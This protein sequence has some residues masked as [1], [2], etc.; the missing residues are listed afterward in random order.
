MQRAQES[1]DTGDKMLQ[2]HYYDW[3]YFLLR[4][5]GESTQKLKENYLGVIYQ[6]SWD[7]SLDLGPSKKSA[8]SRTLKKI[9]R[10]GRYLQSYW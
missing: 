4:R 3:H 6:S 5:L 10:L 2:H 9:K 7:L 8:L 1:A